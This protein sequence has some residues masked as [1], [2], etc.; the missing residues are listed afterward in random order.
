MREGQILTVQL[1]PNEE[2]TI[3]L[4]SILKTNVDDTSVLFLFVLLI[5]LS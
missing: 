5:H 2:I 4:E 1:I 3:L